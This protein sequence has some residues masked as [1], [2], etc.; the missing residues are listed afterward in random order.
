MKTNYLRKR[1][2]F[3]HSHK[4]NYILASFTWSFFSSQAQQTS[5]SFD[6]AYAAKFQNALDSIT[7]ALTI[8]GASMALIIPVQGTF[9]G[10]SGES[11]SGVPITP[12]MR[13]GIGSN[14]KL[15]TAV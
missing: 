5:A 15:F 7:N 10:V 1:I 2:L 6:P 14:T 11:Y 8:R 4:K 12:D 9:I 13:F 3:N